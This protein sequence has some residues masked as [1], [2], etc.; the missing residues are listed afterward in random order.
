M[1]YMICIYIYTCKYIYIYI[2]IYIL[3]LAVT[4]FCEGLIFAS[5]SCYIT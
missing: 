1:I 4:F 3:P 5:V 2:Y